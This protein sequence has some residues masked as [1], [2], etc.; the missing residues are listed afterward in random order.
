MACHLRKARDTVPALQ[1]H[2]KAISPWG[3]RCRGGS[4]SQP[5]CNTSSMTQYSLHVLCAHRN[6]Q[7]GAALQSETPLHNALENAQSRRRQALVTFT[8]SLPISGQVATREAAMSRPAPDAASGGLCKSSTQGSGCCG[9]VWLENLRTIPTRQAVRMR[10]IASRMNMSRMPMLMAGVVKLLEPSE[11]RS[12]A[13]RSFCGPWPPG[14]RQPLRQQPDRKDG[15]TCKYVSA[16]S[17]PWRARKQ[18]AAFVTAT[19]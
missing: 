14:G 5:T 15:H 3:N 10:A 18:R 17:Q 4:G 19:S 8:L 13:T 2:A 7:P 1:K 16:G 9:F 12:P 11:A 6:S